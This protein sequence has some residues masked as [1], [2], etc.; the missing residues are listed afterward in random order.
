M[1]MGYLKQVGEYL[2]LS[3][4]AR[5]LDVLNNH[6]PV[7]GVVQ[8]A[9]RVRRAEKKKSEMEYNSALFALL[10]EKRKELADKAGVPPYV[11]FSDRT[12]IEMAAF[13]PQSTAG[14][15]NI[16]GV[17]QVKMDRFG[18]P[19]LAVIKSYC[20]KHGLKEI[21][22]P[23]PLRQKGNGGSRAPSGN[24]SDSQTDLPERTRLVAEAFNEGATVNE[25]MERHQVTLGTILEHLTKYSM[26]GNTLRN[27]E[28]L[29]ALVTVT[30][31]QKRAAFEA[32]QEL[33]P[34][35]LKPIHE[36]L[37]GALNYDVLRILR[38]LHLIT[39]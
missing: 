19:F 14:L 32:F 31:D 23:Q 22:R 35:L 1:T 25:L 28:D 27:D 8:E 34:L 17:R 26:A 16:S 9:E 13:Y 21:P 18:E 33:D 24:G 6:S 38:L 11:I 37:N 12:L 3:I 7:M 36:R 29:H 4:T 39:R 2:T 10:R 5:G 20:S 30:P 15:L